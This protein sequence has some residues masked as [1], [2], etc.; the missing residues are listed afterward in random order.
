VLLET[1]R[2]E[3]GLLLL[4]AGL[5]GLVVGSFLNVVIHRLP[6]MMM[7][8]W[9]RDASQ[10]LGVEHGADAAETPEPV[11][12]VT[13]RSH[14]PHCKSPITALQNI[15][16]LSWLWLRGRCAHCRARIPVRYPAVE[17]VCGLLSV[18]VAWHFGATPQTLAGLILTWALL[19]A[20][21][22]DM[23]H[24]LLPD[25]IVL[26][27]LWLGL[28]ANLFGLFASTRSALIGAMAGYMA[29]WLIFQIFRLTTGKEGMG[30]GDFK[31]L[32]LLGAWLGWQYLPAV[33]V[34][35]SAV[36]AVVGI[37]MMVGGRMT[38]NV[39][40]P[41]GPFLAAAGWLALIW[42]PALNHAY[43]HFTGLG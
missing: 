20:A 39:P 1:L 18:A 9:R 21:I 29:L 11:N 23:Q 2:A 15:P 32:A 16:I 31:L 5:L 41:F 30:R 34:I 17:L 37:A 14:C 22:I 33:V 12:L 28:L 38:R 7:A 3:P 24:Q 19:A 43:L 27:I 40:M 4:G 26:P 35:A 36:G 13:P 42:G 10:V 8:E 25:D 6:L